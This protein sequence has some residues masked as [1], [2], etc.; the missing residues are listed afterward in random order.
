MVE[1][2]EFDPYD[3]SDVDDNND[4]LD[5]N[6]EIKNKNPEDVDKEVVKDIDISTSGLFFNVLQNQF[7]GAGVALSAIASLTKGTFDI[8]DQIGDFAEMLIETEVGTTKT[9]GN[10]ALAY[11]MYMAK[12]IAAGRK[13]ITTEEYDETNPYNILELKSISNVLDKAIIKY[14]DKET[15]ENL[16]SLDLIEA[17]EFT[18]ASEVF[19]GELSG[20]APSMLISRIPGGYALLG[21]GSFTEKFNRDLIERQ[22]QDVENIL[23]NSII[24]GG[25]DAIGEYFGG[26]FLNN[27]GKAVGIGKLTPKAFKE[28]SIKT[29]GNTIKMAFKGGAGESMQEVIT[30]VVQNAGDDIIYGDEV[31]ASQ[32]F[33]QALH[34]G[35]I[36][37]G[38]GAGSG[39]FSSRA[40]G[41]KDQRTKMAEYFAPGSYKVQQVKLSE[42][43]QEAQKNYENAPKNKKDYFKKKVDDVKQ[44]KKD[45]QDQ[46]YERFVN[47]SN[48]ETEY[49]LDLEQTRHDALD[50]INGGKNYSD[51]AK[52]DAKKDFMDATNSL[53]DLFAVTD[54]NY[55]KDVEFEMSNFVRAAQEIDK[56]NENL[57]FKAKD[58]EYNYVDSKEEL[59]K[60]KKQYGKDVGNKADGFFDVTEDG[61][62]KIFINRGVAAAASATNVIGHELLHYA[63]SNKFANDPK[64][65]RESIIGFNK[66]LDKVDPNI[67][68][69]IEKRLSN[70]KNEYALLDKNGKAQKD[71]DGLIIMKNDGYI[72][73]YF[74][75][76]SDLIK[77]KRI[78]VVEEASVG[79]KNN[80]RTMLR[81]LGI[82]ASSVDFKSGQEVFNLLIDYNKNIGRT[83]FLG[84]ITQKKAIESVGGKKKQKGKA[85]EVKSSRSNLIDDINDLQQGATT[86]AEFQKSDIFN[87]VFESVQPNGAVSNYIKSLQMSPEKTQETID[88]VTDRLVNFDP[89]AKRKDGSVIGPKGLGEFIMA[90]V[91]FGKLDAAKK[92]FKKGEKAKRETSIDTEEAKELTNESTQ[93]KKQETKGQKARVL[94][95]LADVNI[96]NKEVVSSTARAEI[97]SLIEQ[98]PKNLEQS[99]KNI[100]DK[101]ITKAVKAQMGKISNVKG[102]VVISEEYKAFIALNYENIVKSLDVTTIKNN[103]KTLFELTQIGKE[104][105]KTKRKGKKDSNFRKGIYKIETNKAKFTKF[106]TEGGYTTLLA[107]QKG[108]ANQIAKGIV[109][110]VVNN[111]IINNSENNAAV[112]SA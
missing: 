56:V 13:G 1:E 112:V 96:N 26:R 107:R 32:Y 83:G 15:G 33:R 7:P 55:N 102:E 73:E 40:N 75:M 18:K 46:M 41:S 87:K 12:R 17:G 28:I 105:K 30:S 98:N 97:N 24:F 35:I 31:S 5:N 60:L 65:L 22:D 6:V 111:E 89:A 74:T 90:N 100:I 8:V 19:L 66:Y 67:K 84:R 49:F 95:S 86:K 58:L 38:L 81:G 109:E 104:D 45:L 48:T 108:L 57:W 42:Q 94:K 76:F 103:Y 16:N 91:G 39:S 27:L 85:G 3:M 43:E 106:F 34:S 64:M 23:S 68:K 59:D 11:T 52:E 25:A 101:E 4:T 14:K 62:K 93:T 44:Q 50:I 63:I 20:A 82:G 77:N 92:L 71:K 80:F 99:I 47:Y 53:E 9:G 36:G 78:D 88:S 72:E 21:G 70:P 79:I 61:V 110:D 37:F 29:I 2:N 54:I 69:A 51:K 10:R